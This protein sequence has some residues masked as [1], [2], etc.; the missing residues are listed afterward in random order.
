MTNKEFC[1]KYNVSL[2]ISR[3]ITKEPTKIRVATFHVYDSSDSSDPELIKMNKY[4]KNNPECE[5]I[6]WQDF[7]PCSNWGY[8]I[9]RM[10]TQ[11][12]FRARILKDIKKTKKYLNLIKQN[13]L[14][15]YISEY[16]LIIEKRT[17]KI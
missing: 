10:E 9:W 5:K 6:Y 4:L 15:K 14:P 13:P 11:K 16:F 17:I 1:N 8:D 12:E 2:E 3:R 7:G